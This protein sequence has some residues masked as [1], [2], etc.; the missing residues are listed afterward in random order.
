MQFERVRFQ[1]GAGYE[2]AGRIDL[3]VDADPV[4]FAVFSHCF[5][6][7]KNL[8]AVGRITSA[9]AAGGIATLR[10]DFT[11]LGESDGDFAASTFTTNVADLVAAAEYVESR[12]AAPRLLVGH[13]LG[14]S[15]AIRASQLLPS[16]DAVAV[17]GTPASPDHVRR[18]IT[19]DW[20][21]MEPARDGTVIV[22]G[23]PV[24]LEQEF[25]EDIAAASLEESV[26]GFRQGLLVLHSPVDNVVGIDNAGEL[27]AAARHPK[28]FVSLDDADHLLSDDD[29][30][31]Y[32]GEVIAAWSARY[33]DIDQ[34]TVKQPDFRTEEP[35]SVTVVRTEAGFRTDVLSN[36]FSMIA[37]EPVEL[38]GMNQG[39][40]PYDYLMVALGACTSMTLRMYADRK[41]W[42]LAAVTV[43][44]SHR[45]VHAKDLDDVEHQTGMVDHVDRRIELIGPLDEE[46][47]LRLRE[48]ADRCP[49]HKT[50]H[51]Q[52]VVTTELA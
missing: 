47:R 25:L 18:H 45:K 50:L 8:S 30:A 1:G 14:G 11:G 48:I 4:G 44:L 3:P 39:P 19:G 9:L 16:V 6:C 34:S 23:R 26:V 52:V 37:D 2:L 13:S 49:V 51:S 33:L 17:I 20:R 40:G 42:P 41:G 35:E 12:Y 5:T 36:G 15:V 43:R 31:R 21:G 7:T 24:R 38:G 29:D 28:S 46:Q 22:A 32:A 10:F 27:F